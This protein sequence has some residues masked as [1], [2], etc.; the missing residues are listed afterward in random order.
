M[1]GTLLELLL[2]PSGVVDEVRDWRRERRARR[3]ARTAEIPCAVRVV[4]GAYPRLSGRWT[5]GTARVPPGALVFEPNSPW[6]ARMT[7]PVHSATLQPPGDIPRRTALALGPQARRI[8]LETATATVE[9]LV[10]ED[11]LQRSMSVTRR[12]VRDAGPP[13]G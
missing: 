10:P 3:L 7:I 5:R 9:W 1:L 6:R 8:V 12:S 4:D 13:S 2:D 11:Q